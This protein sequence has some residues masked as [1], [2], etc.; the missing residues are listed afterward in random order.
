MDRDL[1]KSFKAESFKAESL[2]S[3]A[4]SFSNIPDSAKIH[5][6]LVENANQQKFLFW[7]SSE[8]LL[9]FSG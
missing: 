2:G 1:A 5:L 7:D 3:V 6:K 4:R 9:G 8:I